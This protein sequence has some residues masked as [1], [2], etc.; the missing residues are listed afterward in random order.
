MG[1]CGKIRRFFP[2]TPCPYEKN[3]SSRKASHRCLFVGALG[4]GTSTLTAN[5]YASQT[6]SSLTIG[7][8]AVVTFGGG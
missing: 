7:A 4:T 2:S 1:D 6:L 3:P 8:V 5:I